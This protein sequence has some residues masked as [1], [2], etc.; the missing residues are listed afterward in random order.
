MEPDGLGDRLVGINGREE[1]G[2][3]LLHLVN[4]REEE[5]A[6]LL[7]LVEPVDSGGGLFKEATAAL[8]LHPTMVYAVRYELHQGG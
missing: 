4:G 6:D 7:H 5:G 2:A 3:D 1:E 8:S